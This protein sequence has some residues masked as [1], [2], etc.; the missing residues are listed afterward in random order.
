[1]RNEHLHWSPQNFILK[2]KNTKNDLEENMDTALSPCFVLDCPVF[3]D[4]NG[5]HIP[6]GNK[7]FQP[8][9]RLIFQRQLWISVSSRKCRRP[10]GKYSIPARKPFLSHW[11]VC[12]QAGKISSR[13]WNFQYLLERFPAPAGVYTM[14]SWK[15]VLQHFQLWKHITTRQNLV[16]ILQCM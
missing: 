6:A 8:D 7:D 16:I 10:S 12:D 9:F 1:M 13:D 5:L 2:I 3:P 15:W 14:P 11:K 4:E